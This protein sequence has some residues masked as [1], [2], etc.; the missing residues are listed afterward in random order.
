[1]RYSHNATVGRGFVDGDRLGYWEPSRGGFAT[2]WIVGRTARFKAAIAEDSIANL[3]IRY[4]ITDTPELLSRDLGRRPHEIPD[5]YCAHSLIT[6]A[7]RCSTSTMLLL[8]EDNLRVNIG[9]AEQFR[10]TRRDV[11]CTT[12]LFRIAQMVV[13][14]RPLSLPGQEHS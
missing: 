7:H 1:M 5:A 8:G 14:H 10:R 13:A 9:E 11:G 2:F 3:R 4:F 6:Y 12:E